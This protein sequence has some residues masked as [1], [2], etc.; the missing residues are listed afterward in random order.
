MQKLKRAVLLQGEKRKEN[1]GGDGRKR[2]LLGTERRGEQPKK[3]GTRGV[4][5]HVNP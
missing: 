3:A 4:E 1:G 5:G 2:V